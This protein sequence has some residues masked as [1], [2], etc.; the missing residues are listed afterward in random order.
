[1]SYPLYLSGNNN[2]IGRD[3]NS[4]NLHKRTN[5][6]EQENINEEYDQETGDYVE[7]TKNNLTSNNINKK[8]DFLIKFFI[9]FTV[10]ILIFGFYVDIFS[11]SNK[12]NI[13][14]NDESIERKLREEKQIDCKRIEFENISKYIQCLAESS[15]ILIISDTSEHI[16]IV[17]K[18]KKYDIDFKHINDIFLN[19]SDY[20]DF[21]K[22]LEEKSPW[23]FVEGTFIGNEKELELYEEHEIL[24]NGI[25]YSEVKPTLNEN[26]INLLSSS[27]IDEND[28]NILKVRQYLRRHLPN[29]EVDKEMYHIK[30]LI[31]AHKNI[32]NNNNNIDT[33]NNEDKKE[34]N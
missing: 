21:I 33:K 8:Y 24:N 9:S 14:I 2:F 7:N 31:Q 32:R 15:H 11:N 23:I 12:K 27:K 30:H 10:F 13:K 18:Y 28:I 22:I 19:V 17:E 3:G 4:L 6:N 20:S 16:D 1:M 26:E 34:N 29:K 5:K 25:E